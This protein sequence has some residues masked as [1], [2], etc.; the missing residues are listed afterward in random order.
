MATKAT[1]EK[2][3]SRRQKDVYEYV[4]M[5]IED[6]GYSPTIREIADGI[7]L[8]SASTVHSHVNSLI[9]KGYL[10]HS[11]G[12]VRTL[13]LTKKGK[14]PKVVTQAGIMRWIQD[15]GIE[16]TNDG[17]VYNLLADLQEGIQT[18]RIS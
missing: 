3:L 9:R 1:L 16:E 10:T 6:N 14:R 5:F 15:K 18:G 8:S 13:A 2:T 4:R 17:A 7:M 11:S 12:G